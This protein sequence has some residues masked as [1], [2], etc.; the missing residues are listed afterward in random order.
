MPPPVHQAHEAVLYQVDAFTK[1]P[2]RGNPAGVMVLEDAIAEARMQHIAAEMNLA[3]TAFL[4]KR[5]PHRYHLRWFTPTVEVELCGHAT[6]ASA[7]ILWEHG[8]V[9]AEETIVFD[10]L[11]GALMA[12][13]HDGQIQLDFPATP[14][15]PA[16]LPNGVLECLGL[17]D[18]LYTG[19]SVFDQFIEVASEEILHSLRPSLSRLRALHLESKTR[20]VIVTCKAAHSG[21]DFMSRFF[22][23]AAGVD[24]DPVTGSAHC[25]LAPYWVGQLGRN[26]LIGYQASK[27][28]GTVNVET[29]RDR[30][31]LRGNAVTVFELNVLV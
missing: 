12:T 5:A 10:T 27:R 26:P 24:E 3:E 8:H 6:L 18:P 4:V 17:A 1:Q 14:P 7:H 13:P 25:A 16:L 22:A 21:A 2:F 29:K 11:S 28:G 23:P 20:G 15:Q 19:E 9:P 31:L 30:V